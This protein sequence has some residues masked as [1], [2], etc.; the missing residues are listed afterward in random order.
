[1]AHKLRYFLILLI[2][3]SAQGVMAQY[4]PNIGNPNQQQQPANFRDTARNTNKQLTSDQEL[5]TIR[6]QEERKRD[7][8]E[9]RAFLACRPS[10]VKR[11]IRQR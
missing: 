6:S 8:V 3:L 10:L 7:P 9:C 4:N 11:E 1:M 2:C 5:D